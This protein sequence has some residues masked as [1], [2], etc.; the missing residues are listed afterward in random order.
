MRKYRRENKE[1]NGK[2]QEQGPSIK[3]NFIH[4]VRGIA[5]LSANQSLITIILIRPDQFRL[6][7]DLS[8]HGT[9]KVGF[10]ETLVQFQL[11]L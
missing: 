1:N 9:F 6:G 3:V 2:D 5:N 8:I 7:Y 4:V 11:V 10:D